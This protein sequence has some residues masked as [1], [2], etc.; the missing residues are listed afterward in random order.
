MEPGEDARAVIGSCV[1]RRNP[2]LSL[3]Q[4]SR[5]SMCRQAPWRACSK[6]AGIKRGN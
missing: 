6:Q 5:M 3:L 1:T 4:A 2:A